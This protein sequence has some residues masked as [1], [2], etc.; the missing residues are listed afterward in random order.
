MAVS[1]PVPSDI[2]QASTEFRSTGLISTIRMR[3]STVA[4]PGWVSEPIGVTP[5][6]AAAASAAASAEA[7]RWPLASPG[8]RPLT[9][10]RAL[11]A[12][13]GAGVPAPGGS[14]V[15]GSAAEPCLAATSVSRD[16]TRRSAV[17]SVAAAT[18]AAWRSAS[19]RTRLSTS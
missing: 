6:A 12:G 4:R 18:L 1:S 2:S 19:T 16:V 17:S 13:S 3:P 5:A 7:E 8:T 9:R 15:P 11:G 10:P 14:V